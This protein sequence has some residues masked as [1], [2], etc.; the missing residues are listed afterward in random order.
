MR[1]P[2]CKGYDTAVKDS[3]PDGDSRIRKYQC[4]TC[5]VKFYTRERWERDP[6]CIKRRKRQNRSV[7]K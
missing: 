6:K 4:F 3:R 7:S 5:G 1:C 2:L